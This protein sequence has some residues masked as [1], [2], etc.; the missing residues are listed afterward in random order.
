MNSGALAAL[1]A[2]MIVL[3]AVPSVSVLAVTA[4]AAS[5]GFSHG[6]LVALGIV[7]GDILFIVLAIFGLM[8]L[9]ERLG[10]AFVW[11]RYL[12]GAYLILLGLLTWRARSGHG[13][14]AGKPGGTRFSSFVTGLAITLADQKAILFY[15]GFFP[16][17]LDVAALSVMEAMQVIIAAAVAVGGVK[18]AYAWSAARAGRVAGPGLASGLNRLAAVIM[19][20][21]G[22]YLLLRQ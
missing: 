5:A 21:A 9:A 18:L 4:R 2:A 6:A 7:A 16:A 20:V 17:F 19:I 1:F 14:G 22:A 13:P 11:V 15:F 10:D 8:L 3:A 12:G